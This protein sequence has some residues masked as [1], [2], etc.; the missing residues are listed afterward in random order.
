V[1]GANAA[2]AGYARGVTGAI[3]DRTAQLDT[4]D[5]MKKNSIDF[6]AEMRSIIVSTGNLKLLRRLGKLVAITQL[7]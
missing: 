3:D 6:Y 7:A 5:E 1:G 2:Y 4:L